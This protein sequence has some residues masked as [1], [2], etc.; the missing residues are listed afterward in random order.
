MCL[1]GFLCHNAVI[2][3]D[4]KPGYWI[5]SASKV[6]TQLGVRQFG[7]S[8]VCPTRPRSNIV[9][10]VV[11]APPLE[12]QL[13]RKVAKMYN[14]IRQGF[15][16]KLLLLLDISVC[17][18]KIGIMG[19]NTKL[20]SSKWYCGY[21]HLLLLSL[22]TSELFCQWLYGLYVF[23]VYVTCAI[24]CLYHY[25][26]FSLCV[27]Q[28]IFYVLY[29]EDTINIYTTGKKYGIF[30]IS[31]IFCISVEFYQ[32]CAGGFNDVIWLWLDA[33]IVDNQKAWQTAA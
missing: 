24:I 21:E 27:F 16:S 13:F 31:M 22:K 25:Y 3:L 18:S 1:Q 9:P 6:S 12:E 4:L 20:I 7:S 5:R 30:F 2:C 17:S 28:F 10:Y 19:V 23:R 15:N 29:F 8:G 26:F 11:G 32:I 14:A 33:K